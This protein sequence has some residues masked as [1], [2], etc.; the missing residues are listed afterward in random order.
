[1]EESWRRANVTGPAA[2]SGGGT[3]RSVKPNDA[4]RALAVLEAT[5]KSEVVLTQNVDRLHQAAG[6]ARVIDLHG[7]LNQV[8]CMG[9]ERRLPRDAF[10]DELERRNPRWIG[11]TAIEAPDGDA[12]LDDPDF[13]S[14]VVPPCGPCGGVQKPDVVFFGETVPRERVDAAM[15]HL[16]R[17][18]AVLI[19]GSSLMVYSGFRFV[20]AAA[21]A[22]KPIAAVNLGK[23]RADDLLSFKVEQPCEAAWPS[24]WDDQMPAATV[25]T[26][27]LKTGRA[28]A[29]TIL[30]IAYMAAGI[31]HFS[32]PEPFVHVTPDWV[33]VPH[34]VIFLTGL[35]EIAGALCMLTGRLR[36]T[37][38]VALALY[39]IC[40]YPANLKHAFE[41][42]VGAIHL[43]WWY[44]GPRL[45]F[46][47]VLV[48]WALFAGGIVDWP[49]RKSDHEPS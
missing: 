38:G 2:W 4:H 46:Q 48:W 40:V 43:G 20:Q 16:D 31:L 36:R 6:S 11:L 9:C 39:A 37:A 33:P 35:C 13:A 29:R 49:F 15:G 30:A 23:T 10:Q 17:A 3:S 41:N 26:N 19:V 1:M 32:M 7:R 47:P 14:F 18:D 27:R 8:R 21:R 22:G 45:A 44:H 5:G 28:I 12:D 42:P 34:T 25:D 24:C